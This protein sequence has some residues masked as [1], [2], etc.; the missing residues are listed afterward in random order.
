MR[1]LLTLA[2]LLGLPAFAM[3]QVPT[4][5][6]TAPDPSAVEATKDPGSFAVTHSGGVDGALTVT[7]SV[8]GTA[9]A[10]EDYPALPGSVTIAAGESVA[11]IKVMPIQDNKAEKAETVILTLTENPAY[12]VGSPKSA[13]VTIKDK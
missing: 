1:I 6:V 2:L 4:V 13:T 7:Y 9:K 5:T 3:A 10:G 12:V 8:G 11:E